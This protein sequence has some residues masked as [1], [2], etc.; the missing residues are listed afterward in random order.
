MFCFIREDLQ[1][2]SPPLESNEERG[3]TL[4]ILY[5]GRVRESVLGLVNGSDLAGFWSDLIFFSFTYAS[6]FI[7]FFADVLHKYIHGHSIVYDMS[8]IVYHTL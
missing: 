4:E 2:S 8:D 3:A 1:Q 6:F 5:I 7:F